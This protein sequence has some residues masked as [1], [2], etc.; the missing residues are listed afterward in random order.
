MTILFMFV[1]FSLIERDATFSED[2]P[3]MNFEQR[4]VASFHGKVNLKNGNICDG[5]EQFI[6][7]W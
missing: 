1:G 4:S 6:R 2:R 5:F 3:N 7:S